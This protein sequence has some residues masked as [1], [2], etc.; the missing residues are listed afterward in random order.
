MS[1]EKQA[2]ELTLDELE[3][4]RSEHVRELR[5]I[6][7]MTDEQFEAFKRNFSLGFIDPS[8]SRAEAIEILRSMICT[9]INIQQDK[10]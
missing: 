9:N 6:E 8:I 2:P 5:R 4:S 3:K 7:K 10:K 1:D